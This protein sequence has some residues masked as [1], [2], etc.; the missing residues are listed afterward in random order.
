MRFLFN[1]F[2]VGVSIRNMCSFVGYLYV[3]YSGLITSIGEE[4]AN[5]S[6]SAYLKLCGF[7]SERLPLPLG[8]WDGLCYIYCGTS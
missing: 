3:R 8:T 6:A 4:R 7:C 1:G 5:L 2:G